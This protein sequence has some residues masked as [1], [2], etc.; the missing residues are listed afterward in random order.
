MKTL[1]VYFS[2]E[3]GRT[4]KKAEEI[5]AIAGAD[6][7]EIKPVEPYT[8]A[9][10]YWPNFKCRSVVEMHTKGF[11]PPII[12]DDLPDIAQYDVIFLGFPIWCAVCPQAVNTF[13]EALDFSGKTIVPFATSGGSGWG[14]TDEALYP[15]CSPTTVWKP[16]KMVNRLA[17]AQ[18]EAWVKQYI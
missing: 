9:D 6:L 5:A 3:R 10:V 12:T 18:M 4:K 16:G 11:R 8:K 15:S 7:Y 13:L 14:P 17:G 2:A 1:V